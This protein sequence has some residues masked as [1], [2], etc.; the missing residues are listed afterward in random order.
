MCGNIGNISISMVFEGLY[1]DARA[2]SFFLS[3]VVLFIGHNLSGRSTNIQA[4]TLHAIESFQN[5]F[6]GAS[7]KI[8]DEKIYFA[9]KMT[10]R[11]HPF[12]SF[13]TVTDICTRPSISQKKERIRIQIR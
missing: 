9:I 7:M 2:F 8:N 10:G 1:A 6:N 4:Q 11:T 12:V 3:F 13:S 5:D